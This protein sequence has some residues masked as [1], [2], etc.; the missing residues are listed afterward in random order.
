MI[1]SYE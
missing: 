1:N